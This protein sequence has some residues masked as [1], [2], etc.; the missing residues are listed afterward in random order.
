MYSNPMQ[1]DA[2][3]KLSLPEAPGIIDTA[4]GQEISERIDIENTPELKKL[5]MQE[6]MSLYDF[7]LLRSDQIRDAAPY[8]SMLDYYPLQK[9]PFAKRKD[10]RERLKEKGFVVNLVGDGD[11]ISFSSDEKFRSISSVASTEYVII[12]YQF[13][14]AR[15]ELVEQLKAKRRTLIIRNGAKAPDGDNIPFDDIYRVF[16]ESFGIAMDGRVQIQYVPSKTDVSV[17]ILQATKK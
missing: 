9:Y 14:L 1:E 10:Y 16:S 3:H 4:L 5:S 7:L 15:P 12:L 11:R 2:F 8:I 13:L 17:L 6:L